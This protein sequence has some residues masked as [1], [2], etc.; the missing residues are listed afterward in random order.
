MCNIAELVMNENENNLKNSSSINVSN[1]ICNNDISTEKR[2]LNV[3]EME[4]TINN[5][6]E[7]LFFFVLMSIL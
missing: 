3:T 2:A 1:V 6:M 4:M 7:G 5:I